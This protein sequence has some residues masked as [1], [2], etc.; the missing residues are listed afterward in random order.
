MLHTSYHVPDSFCAGTGLRSTACKKLVPVPE[1]NCTRLTDACASFWYTFLERVA[2]LRVVTIL[3]R[4]G[5]SVNLCGWL[6]TSVIYL[7][8]SHM[9]NHPICGGVA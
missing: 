6:H 7:S 5:G 1:K 3:W 9:V 4:G 2:G 8:W